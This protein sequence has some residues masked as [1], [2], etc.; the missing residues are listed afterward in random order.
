MYLHVNLLHDI[1]INEF[2]RYIFDLLL[3]D[4]KVVGVA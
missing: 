1:K 2:D 4:N 3:I